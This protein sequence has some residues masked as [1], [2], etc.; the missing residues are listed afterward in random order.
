MATRRTVQGIEVG[1]YSE[2]TGPLTAFGEMVMAGAAT[3]N[4]TATLS[5]N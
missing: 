1:A 4:V 5:E 3:M 2:I